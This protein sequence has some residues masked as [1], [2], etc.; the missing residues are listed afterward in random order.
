MLVQLKSVSAMCKDDTKAMFLR[1]KIVVDN[2]LSESI[3]SDCSR[4]FIFQVISLY[5]TFIIYYLIQILS[6]G[7]Q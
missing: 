2:Q 5:F 1:P 6:I 7:R 3:P 4:S